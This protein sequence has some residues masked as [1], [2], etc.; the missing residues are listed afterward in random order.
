[1]IDVCESSIWSII[2]T[3]LYTAMSASIARIAFTISG[4]SAFSSPPVRTATAKL[5]S[6]F[7]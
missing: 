7:R 1:M 4:S 2:V 3:G 6:S 5:L